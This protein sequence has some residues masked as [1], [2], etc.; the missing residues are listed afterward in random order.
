MCPEH[1]YAVCQSC[2]ERKGFPTDKCPRCGFVPSS[3]REEVVAAYLS[4]FRFANDNQSRLEYE[5]EVLELGRKIRSGLGV[6]YEESEL[7]RLESDI[8]V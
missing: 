8:K 3:P 5:A 4:S 6:S 1:P 7:E 2:G